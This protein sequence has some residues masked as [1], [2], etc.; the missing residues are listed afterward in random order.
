[1]AATENYFA[2]ARA[3]GTDR[4][5]VLR[6]QIAASLEILWNLVGPLPA[7][8]SLD[9]SLAAGAE[10]LLK[11]HDA[12]ADGGVAIRYS[13]LRGW[14][15]SYPE[16]TGYIIPTFIELNKVLGDA[17]FLERARQMASWEV[18][19]Q[20]GNGFYVGGAVDQGVGPTV[21]DTG[22]I[23]LGLL[24]AYSTWGDDTALGAARKAGRA[25]CACQNPDGSWSEF[26][27]NGIPHTYHSRVAWPLACLGRETGSDEFV[28]A[29]HRNIDWVLGN[30]QANGWFH[31]GG[32]T[33]RDHAAPLTHTIA[34][35]I[36]GILEVG[37]CSSVDKYIGA[38]RR[39]ADGLLDRITDKGYL[40]GRLD[41]RWQAVDRYA[42]LTGS[43]QMAVIYW[44]LFEI[45]GDE[46]HRSAARRLNRFLRESQQRSRRD[47][48]L[49][50]ALAGSSPIWGGY[51]RFAFPNWATK[52]LV[53]A[54]LLERRLD[55]GIGGRATAGL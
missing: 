54:L 37:L 34:Y 46:N 18:E 17:R 39:S 55:G 1:V 27:Y 23:V 38:A 36:R 35:T 2:P 40:N 4:E 11:A 53:D 47:S 9:D 15:A 12:T 30:Q 10:W 25:L 43:A 5:V 24:A 21:F 26:A 32:F 52:F 28:T 22:Q 50:G 48:C 6:E 41:Y 51:E 31:N 16:T 13:L 3:A 29:A 45:L 44:K 49:A 33:D 8:T 19:I 7:S 14:Q 20:L 42:C